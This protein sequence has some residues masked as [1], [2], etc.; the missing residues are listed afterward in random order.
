[1]NKLIKSTRGVV[2]SK[3]L[4]AVIIAAGTTGCFGPSNNTEKGAIQGAVFGGLLG[5]VIG[6]QSGKGGEGAVI[7]AA[8]GALLGGAAGNEE[9]KKNGKK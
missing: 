6:H 1:M 2:L 3:W 4:V 9:D 7:G 5:G 8:A